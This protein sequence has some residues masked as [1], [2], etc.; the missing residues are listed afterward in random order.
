MP[1]V[2]PPGGRKPYPCCCACVACPQYDLVT[3]VWAFTISGLALTSAIGAGTFFSSTTGNPLHTDLNSLISEP[4]NFTFV[5]GTV[6]RKDA[7]YTSYL[8]GFTGNTWTYSF[9]DG[10]PNLTLRDIQVRFSV[11][12]FCSRVW[13][14]QAEIQAFTGLGDSVIARFDNISGEPSTPNCGATLSNLMTQESDFLFGNL[15]ASLTLTPP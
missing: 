9:I 1:S 2:P 15:S 12:D 5:S 8:L 13:I 7:V 6:G 4:F 10:R 14:L 3:D 11:R